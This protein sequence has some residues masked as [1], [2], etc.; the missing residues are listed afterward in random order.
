ME[1][2]LAGR[3]VSLLKAV[4]GMVLLSSPEWVE[5]MARA[6]QE[7]QLGGDLEEGAAHE[8]AGRPG[9]ALENDLHAWN[10]RFGATELH[11]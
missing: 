4:V 11:Q 1:E 10:S 2:G 9:L 6:S 3:L 8:A 5:R 7:R